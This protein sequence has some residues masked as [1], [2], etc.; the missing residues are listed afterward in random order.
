M[1][2]TIIWLFCSLLTWQMASAQNKPR[3]FKTPVVMCPVDYGIL[4]RQGITPVS[5]S[6]TISVTTFK[7]TLI[8]GNPVPPNARLTATNNVVEVTDTLFTYTITANAGTAFNVIRTV[9]S[10]TLIKLWRFS[11]SEE[12]DSSQISE[13]MLASRL[14]KKDN[15]SNIPANLQGVRSLTKSEKNEVESSTGS[16]Q[17]QKV[18]PSKDFY[19]IKTDDLD[20]YSEEFEYRKNAW[21]IGIM[22]LPVKLRPFATRSGMFDFVSD[23]SVGTSFSK[24]IHHNFINDMTTNLLLYAGL[25]S[26]KVDSLISGGDSAFFKKPQNILSFSPA[27]GMYWEKKGIQ[28]GFVLGMDFL[29]GSLQKNWSYRGMP[30]FALTAGVN[31]FKLTNNSG[32]IKG[33][34]E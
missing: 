15:N 30:W 4:I 29:T 13:Y 17:I 24:T 34:N 16:T 27:I 21:N 7:Q 5:L 9:G 18:D 14:Y 32:S 28:V 2:K 10:F 12:K 11:E 19:L 3:K 25:S 23:L 8:K 20:K 26:V 31:L 6:S 1:K 22:Y 33:E